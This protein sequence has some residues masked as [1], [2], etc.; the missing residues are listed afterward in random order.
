MGKRA[1]PVVLTEEER[2]TISGNV[3]NPTRKPEKRGLFR[4]AGLYKSAFLG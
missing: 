1:I 2:W 4:K 3:L